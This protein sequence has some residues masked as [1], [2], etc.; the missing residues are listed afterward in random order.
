MDDKPDLLKQL[1][2]A[3]F[4]HFLAMGLPPFKAKQLV[5][6]KVV[7]W[8]KLPAERLRQLIEEPEPEY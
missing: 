2:D 1:S 7:E 4:E 8:K 6:E 3:R 5:A